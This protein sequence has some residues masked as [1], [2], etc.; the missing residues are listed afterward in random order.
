MEERANQISV[1]VLWSCLLR[2]TALLLY[3]VFCIDSVADPGQGLGGP[4]PLFLDQTEA[5][6]A[7]KKKLRHGPPYLRVRMTAPSPPPPFPYLKV[8]IRHCD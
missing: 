1:D 8:R 2:S 3:K 5:R 7:E 6:M 4:S